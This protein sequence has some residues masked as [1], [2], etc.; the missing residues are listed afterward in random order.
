[1][2]TEEAGPDQAKFRRCCMYVGKH[3][4]IVSRRVAYI[5]LCFK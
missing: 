5:Y 1:M 3:W 2:R 4:R